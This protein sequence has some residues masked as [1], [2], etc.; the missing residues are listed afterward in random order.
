MNPVNREPVQA[1]ESDL[2]R[3]IEPLAS[4]IC[5]TDQPMAAMMAALA[6]LFSEVDETYRAANAQITTFSGNQWS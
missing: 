4:N 3:V 5:T 6:V 2:E 1:T